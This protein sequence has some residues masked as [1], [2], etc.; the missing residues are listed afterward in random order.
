MSQQ[1]FRSEVM[2]ARRTGAGGGICLAQSLS[3]WM[4]AATALAAAAVVAVYLVCGSYTRRTTV[5]GRLVPVLGLASVVAPAS[6][7]LTRLP[8]QEGAHVVAGEVLAT[9]A[10][11]RSSIGGGTSSVELAQSLRERRAALGSAQRGQQRALSAQANGLTAQIDSMHDELQQVEVQIATRERQRRISEDTLA[12][13]RQLQESQ[14]A[15][16]SQLQA[17]ESAVLEQLLALQELQRQQ[18]ALK[19]GILQ[20]QQSLTELPGQREALAAGM[21][22]DLAALMQEQLQMEA[23]S[24]VTIVSPLAGVVAAQIVKPGQSVQQGQPLLSVLPGDGRLEAEL[25]VPSRAAGFIAAGDRVLLRY[26]AYP[27]QKFG[28]Q[29]GRV[30]SVSRSALGANEVGA[31]L[32]NTGDGQPLYRVSVALAGQVIA[33]YDRAEALKPGMLLDADILGEKRRLV[34]WLFEPLYSMRGRLGGS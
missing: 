4:L 21:Q 18:S 15:S 28:H 16:R 26:Q 14:Y 19:R 5:T 13:L 29:Q 22:R 8:V 11:P 1:L 27:Y 12:Q 2:E 24:G 23:P 6:G 3:L 20:L 10:V 32:G 31:L 17:Q 34:E 7:V 9:I 30:A 33:A 25:L